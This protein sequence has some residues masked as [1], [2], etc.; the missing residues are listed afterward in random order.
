[1]SSLILR[2]G[3]VEPLRDPRYATLWVLGGPD[4][5]LKT[6]SAAFVA[7]DP[8][9]VSPLHWHA[10]T[11]ELYMIV[12]GWGVMHLDGEDFPV[13]PGD[14]ISIPLGVVHAIGASGTEPLTMWV[15]TSPPYTDDD[16]FEV[17]G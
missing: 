8:G 10:L 17:E 14:S 16:D 13:G 2:R 3:G 4:T 11:E 6:L 7:V 12:S 9:A 15:A 1:M 5:G